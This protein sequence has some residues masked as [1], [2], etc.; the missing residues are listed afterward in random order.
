MALPIVDKPFVHKTLH[1]VGPLPKSARGHTHIL[2]IIDYTSWYPKG[3]ALLSIMAKVLA[4]E[5]LVIF[6]QIGFASAILMD[7][8]TISLVKSCW[9]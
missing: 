1:L 9:V 3:V 5:L 4:R 7:Q 2:V 6:S 8:G